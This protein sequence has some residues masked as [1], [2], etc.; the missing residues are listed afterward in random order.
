M[1]VKFYDFIEDSLIK[2][3]VIVSRFNGKWV[4][5]KHKERN[6]YE[7]P[8][9]H[10]EKN[11]TVRQAAR[12]ELYEETGAV[13]YNL[14][15]VGVYSVIGKTRG[16]E[17]R[18]ENI[19][20]LYY[21]EIRGFEPELHFEIEKIVF[22]ETLPDLP[23]SLTYPFIQPRLIEK[24]ITLGFV[25]TREEMFEYVRKNLDNNYGN[26]SANPNQ[27]FRERYE[28]IIRV[29]QWAE[30]LAEGMKL[31]Y[32]VLITAAIFHDVGYGAGD[33]EYHARR[34]AEIFKQFTLTKQWDTVFVEKVY[35]I[36][37]HHSDKDLLGT[38][39]PMELVIL[40]EADLLDADLKYKKIVPNPMVTEKAKRIWEEKKDLFLE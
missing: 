19:G 14:K 35:D 26:L 1:E 36:I 8:G 4:L 40:M 34:S 30:L 39:I 3:V 28:H 21:A 12:R 24:V 7:V 15:S 10:R 9:G 5:C 20:M 11:E 13:D 6:T 31:D 33:N 25:T 23:D 16:N 17:T 37:L 27:R 29:V 22:M 2:F 38:D 32:N 18:E